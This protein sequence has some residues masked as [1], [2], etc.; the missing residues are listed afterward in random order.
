MN[1]LMHEITQETVSVVID[2][3]DVLVCIRGERFIRSEEKQES[4]FDLNRSISLHVV[5]A[6]PTAKRM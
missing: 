2:S 1:T 3:F 4:V 5:M 6:P